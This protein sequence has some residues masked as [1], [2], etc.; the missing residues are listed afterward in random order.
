[1]LAQADRSSGRAARAGRRQPRALVEPECGASRP[2][3]TFVLRRHLDTV[4]PERRAAD[5][6]SYDGTGTAR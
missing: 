2:L 4:M 6:R 1:M 3:G 5:T